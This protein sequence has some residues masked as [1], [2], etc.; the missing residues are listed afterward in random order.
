MQLL[1]D[2]FFISPPKRSVFCL[3]SFALWNSLVSSQPGLPD[4][5]DS[6]ELRVP[7]YGKKAIYHANGNIDVVLKSK[8]NV[9]IGD[10]TLVRGKLNKKRVKGLCRHKEITDKT[11]VL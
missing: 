5:F 3:Y 1:P 7:R 10:K 11:V 8:G 2:L 9:L 4:I 6:G